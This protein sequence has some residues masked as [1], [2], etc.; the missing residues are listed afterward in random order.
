M[1]APCVALLFT[2]EHDSKRAN[3]TSCS[4]TDAAYTNSLP[5]SFQWHWL[6][7]SSPAVV[8]TEMDWESESKTQLVS[9]T[10]AFYEPHSSQRTRHTNAHTYVSDT[11]ENR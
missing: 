1:P 6:A 4:T 2:K 9:Q 5:L 10:D 7:D 8:A 11:L 3:S